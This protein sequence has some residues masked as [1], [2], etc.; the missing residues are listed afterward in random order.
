MVSETREDKDHTQ[1]DKGL[2]DFDDYGDEERDDLTPEEIEQ[3]VQM[4]KL[5]M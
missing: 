5:R 3:L 1:F 2:D 4:N